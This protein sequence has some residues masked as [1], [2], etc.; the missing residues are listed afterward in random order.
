MYYEYHSNIPILQLNCPYNVFKSVEPMFPW[1]IIN[2][3]SYSLIFTHLSL[4]IDNPDYNQ[5][6]LIRSLHA[7]ITARSHFQP[8]FILQLSMF[9]ASR[10]LIESQNLS[11]KSKPCNCVN[12]KCICE[13]CIDALKQYCPAFFYNDIA[14]QSL[15]YCSVVSCKQ[16]QEINVS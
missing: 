2:I 9:A 11:S 10:F 7:Y 8:F 6:H 15:A 3:K 1:Y 14:P 16:F 4:C 13:T 12:T 5:Q